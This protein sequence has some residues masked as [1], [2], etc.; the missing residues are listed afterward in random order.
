MSKTALTPEPEGKVIKSKGRWRSYTQVI[1]PECKLER[2]VVSYDV[3]KP[4]FTGV[5]RT[6]CANKLPR[7]I[8]SPHWKGGR[9]RVDKGYIRVKLF[10]DDFF[11]PMTN[12][13]GYVL[14]HR[15]VVAKRL[16]RCLHGWE[17]VHHIDH[18][19]DH[20]EDE[21]LQLTS[22]DR[23][24]QFTILETKIDKLLKKQDDLMAEIKL[25]RLQNK[26]LQES[27]K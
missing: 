20:N 2:W 7:G 18:I 13:H 3:R 6:C 19:H 10:S 8:N 21:N 23:H 1:C 16:G 27:I 11:Y 17:I 26:L 12:Q 9:I 4:E 22:D 5:C 25:L 14:E 15:L 24:K